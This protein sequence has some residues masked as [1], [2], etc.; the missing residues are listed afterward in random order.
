MSAGMTAVGGVWYVFF[1]NNLFPDQVFNI[2]RSIELLLGPIIGG[3]GTLFGPILGTFVLQPLGFI[4]SDLTEV[5]GINGI[6]QFFY[7]LCVVLII[8]FLPR[9]IWP[10]LSRRLALRQ[11][12]D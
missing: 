6:Q 7:G 11:D 5:L 12:E 10:W 8:V 4:L 1:S 2:A 9:G 3:V